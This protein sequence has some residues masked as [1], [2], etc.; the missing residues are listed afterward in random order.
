MGS[1]LPHEYKMSDVKED[2]LPSEHKVNSEYIIK[3]LTRKNEL[4]HTTQNSTSPNINQRPEFNYTDHKL[5]LDINSS[6]NIFK[7]LDLIAGIKSRLSPI[8]MTQLAIQLCELMLNNQHNV[9]HDVNIKKVDFLFYLLH[10]YPEEL[11][12]VKSILI[13][14][15][16]EN[17]Y[18]ICLSII[19]TFE[20]NL[21]NFK[22]HSISPD[23]KKYR[24]KVILTSLV[25]Y[26][27]FNNLFKLVY[28]IHKGSKFIDLSTHKRVLKSLRKM[29]ISFRLSFL[30][31]IFKKNEAMNPNKPILEVYD[32]YNGS[33]YEYDN[34]NN[35]NIRENFISKLWKK[36][37]DEEMGKILILK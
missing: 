33:Y 19:K 7:S 35:V 12:I 28:K 32:S 24:L 11:A 31:V 10:V 6:N 22:T 25:V 13:K 9:Y 3:T 36:E 34:I 2:G 30:D 14:N 1:C 26:I 27:G 17:A 23:R 29:L 37:I 5:P 20:E 16:V 4:M 8:Q 21:N 15:D 18:F